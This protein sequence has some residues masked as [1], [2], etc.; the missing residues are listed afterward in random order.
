M[1]E[2]DEEE[3][4]KEIIGH[5]RLELNDP[6][7]EAATMKRILRESRWR[8]IVDNLLL[9]VLIFVAT[10]AF[11]WLGLRLTGMNVSDLANRT[12]ALFDNLIVQAGQVRETA[13]VVSQPAAY[14]VLSI[15]V[16]VALLAII[17]S[18]LESWK[19]GGRKSA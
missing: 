11:I 15:G 16:I 5:S 18:R 19:S 8:K 3:I 1:N 13:S 4:A 14:V 17:E 12:A 2:F 9:N 6:K 7:F 10:D